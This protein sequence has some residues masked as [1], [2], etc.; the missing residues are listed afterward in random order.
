MNRTEQGGNLDFTPQHD[1]PS[2]LYY[3]CTSHGYMIGEI[4]IIDFN[5]PNERGTVSGTTGSLAQNAIGN[6]TITGH[7]SYLLMNV[8][9]SAAG[10]FRLYT[11]SASRTADAN[12]SVGED[13]AAGSGVIAEVVTTA[14][15][16]TQKVTPFVP[17]G[18]MDNPV[19]TNMYV[20]IK[21]LSS[22][23]QTI[24]A[25]LTILKLED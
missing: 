1:A 10:W 7:K 12:R 9:L 19:S 25:T 14:S 17:G 18:N 2:T 3:Q 8:Q 13:P 24:T 11:D 22:T 20:A 16:L 5:L 4:K 6:I 23:T 15:S 21:N